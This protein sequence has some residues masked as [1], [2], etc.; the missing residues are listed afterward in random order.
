MLD[1]VLFEFVDSY[2]YL[3]FFD[4]DGEQFELIVCVNVVGVG[5]MVMICMWMYKE[6]VVCVLVEVY[7]GLFY[8]VGIYLMYVVEEL[9]IL[10]EELV[11]LVW[12]LKFVGIGEIG[13]DYYYIVDSVVVQVESLCIYIEVVC[14][15]GLLLIIYLCDVDEDMVC[16]L[17]EEYCI[18]VFLCVMYCYISGLELVWVVLD[19]G[20]YLLMLGIVVFLCLIEICEIFV[21]V[22][23][24]CILVE[25]DV[26]YLVFLFYCGKCN[27]LFFVVYIVWIGVE[28][29][30]L[31]EVEFCV[32]IIVN[33]DWLFYK[34][35]R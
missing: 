1:F 29:F 26:F 8:V 25:I 23:C 34:V 19:L 18:G 12:Y 31:F 9:L 17:I 6:F 28:V 7:E 22:L 13:L 32:Q 24:D 14:C 16:I 27:E 35:V 2:C 4:F 3:D 30:G 5:C 21:V 20:F 33:F 10:V 11:L 15:I